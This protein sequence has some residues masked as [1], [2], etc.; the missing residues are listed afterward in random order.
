MADRKRNPLLLYGLTVLLGLS[1]P[2]LVLEGVL[3][4]FP[5]TE[6][7]YAK[8]VDQR[9][10]Y[11][12]FRANR[13]IVYSDGWDFQIVTE[14]RVN[15]AGFL[16]DIDYLAS[17]K[18]VLAIIGDSYVEALQVRN[19]ESMHG[20]L[21]TRLGQRG[22]LYAFGASGAPLSQY[23]GYAELAKTHHQA[24]AMTFVIIGN[25]FDQSLAAYKN[26]PGFFYFFENGISDGLS[27]LELRLIPFKGISL[28][29]HLVLRSALWRYL[30]INAGVDFGN[31]FKNPFQRQDKQQDLMSLYV[32]NVLAASSDRR[33]SDSK[34][35]VDAF[36]R[37][38]PS[39]S[40]L[41][42]DKISFVIDGMRPH[43]Y[44]AEDML[45]TNGSYFDLMRN[46]F[47]ESAMSLGY[48]VIDMQPV[49]RSFYQNHGERF[50]F[51]INA[52]WNALGHKL[53]ADEI[54]NST[55]YRLWNMQ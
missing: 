2:F 34:R 38:L 17:E 43:L 16:S 20:L 45:K 18:P 19:D 4:L 36:F 29:G 8:P 42:P 53:V 33:L 48:E 14:K 23:L 26:D 22:L 40:G 11:K 41:A 15:N 24:K 39:K 5:V 7:L 13:E 31:I 1:I 52:H 32:G 30:T 35:A 37:L 9:N 55:T 49:F 6:S 50:E 10:P 51:P 21:N 28:K 54:E 47:I 12:R 27:E 46:Y 25:D 44:S 3:H